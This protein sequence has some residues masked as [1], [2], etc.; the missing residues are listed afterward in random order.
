MTQTLDQ[1]LS[2][3][4]AEMP[5]LPPLAPREEVMGGELSTAKQWTLI[6][7][8][9]R[10]HRLAVAS[11]VFMAVLGVLALFADF[12]S[13]YRPETISRLN[14]F[15]PPN[16]VHIFHEGSLH[17]PF[18]YPLERKRDPETARVIYQPNTE[19]PLPIRFFVEGESYHLLGLYETRVHLFGID[20]RKQQINLLGTDSL[21]RDLFTR[22]LYGARVTLSAGLVGVAFAFILGLA[23]GSISGYY[24]GWLDAGIQRLMEFIRSIPTIPLWMGL[25]AA[26]PIAWDPLF[27]YVLITIIL[28]LI[29][30]THLARV[31]RG[32]FFS[33]KTEDYVLA[34]R[35]AGASEY[36]IVTRHML[37]AM[38]S[39]IIAA[40]TLAI[41]EMILGETALSFL[42]LG[43]RPPVVSWGVLLQDAQNLRTISL[44]PWLLAPGIAVV[45]VVLAFNFIGDGLRDAADPYGH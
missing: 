32:R 16:M 28:S 21:G 4:P 24:G 7:W 38:T 20:D 41:P 22:L 43:L 39:Y 23:L 30:W 31:V 11:L 36:R 6:W 13:P 35:L 14:T 1:T 40:V 5:V 25:A 18:I 45:L 17:R 37:P 33:L 9:F 42:G 44:A 29:G 3:T 12:V 34:A 19:K 8:R 26:L 2:T 10:K 15:A 27:V